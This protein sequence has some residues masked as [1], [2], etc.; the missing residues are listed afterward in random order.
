MR[1]IMRFL[2]GAMLGAVVGAALALLFAPASGE[3]LRGDMQERAQQIQIEV[4]QAAEARRSEL[5][6]QLAELRTPRKAGE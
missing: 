1:G 4:R 2:S 3:D 5:E 6:Q